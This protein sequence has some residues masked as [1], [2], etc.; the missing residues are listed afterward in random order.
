MLFARQSVV[1]SLAILVPTPVAAQE[2]HE[3]ARQGDA[4]AVRALLDENA[5]LV[6]S[7]DDGDA[8]PLHYAAAGGSQEVADMLLARGAGVNAQNHSGE[9]ALHWAVI[10][11]QRAVAFLLVQNGADTELRENYGRTP[12]LW[13]ARET[14][15][16]EIATLLIEAGADVNARD[17]AMDTPLGLAAWRGFEDLVDLLL[18]E[19]AAVPTGGAEAQTLLAFAAEKGLARLFNIVAGG[20][21]DLTVRNDNGGTLL[22]S[23]SE[24]GVKEVVE[25]LLDLGL[26]VNEADRYGRTPLHYAAENGRSEAAEVLIARGADLDARCL[27]GNT[28]LNVAEAHGHA[29][30]VE[31]LVAHGSNRSP[32]AFPVLEGLYFGQAPPGSEPELFA[33]G[34]VS[35][36]RFEHGTVAFSPDGQEAFWSSSYPLP[37]SGYTWS[38]I[39]TSWLEDGR[40]TA[41]EV[42]TFSGGPRAGDDVPFFS[43]D[44]NRVYF[45]SGRPDRLG[46]PTS[47]RIWYVERTADG[48]SEPVVIDGGPNSLDL[49]WQFSVAANGNIYFG[50]GDPSGYGMADIYVSRFVDGRW[51][52]P[53]NL[54]NVVNSE[55]GDSSPYIAPDESYLLFMRN[56]APDGLGGVDIFVSFR[57]GDG[58]W[59]PPVSLGAPVNSPSHD[60]C[61]IVSPDGRY[62][63]FNSFRSGNADNY[64]LGAEIIE[65]LR[66]DGAD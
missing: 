38:R 25:A 65:R 17:R 47:E 32:A 2:I 9:T 7:R 37:G 28:P 18:A 21:V 10:R 13:V 44:G 53:E 55:S 50:S 30:L 6:N 19:G 57:S 39:L 64:W 62:L 51:A 45:I 14:G 23:A 22:H 16:V 24:G 60:I 52:P 49:H 59:T 56:R 36:H 54:G 34:I 1:L 31:L 66:P 48:W 11:N 43:T 46:G 33:P 27:V 40:W 3:A 20:E 8:T 58:V 15:N 4:A 42:A 5:D 26:E 61:P 41:P 63:F 12:L 29:G 35:S